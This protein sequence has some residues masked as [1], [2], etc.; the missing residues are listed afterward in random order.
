MHNYRNG[1]TSAS[2]LLSSLLFYFY[3]S[4][5]YYY[6]Y[7]LFLFS[8]SIFNLVTF[9]TSFVQTLYLYSIPDDN[10]YVAGDS[11]VVIICVCHY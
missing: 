7:F 10:M 6:C 3:H 5:S 9:S 11:N 4:S 2:F 8:F 1:T